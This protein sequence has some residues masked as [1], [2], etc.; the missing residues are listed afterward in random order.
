MS[1][2]VPTD[3]ITRGKRLAAARLH[4]KHDDHLLRSTDS[5]KVP[6]GISRP[7]AVIIRRERVVPLPPGPKTVVAGRGCAKVSSI[8]WH[9][10]SE[11]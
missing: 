9:P 7:V 5:R 11:I 2:L 1:H 6:A 8:A 3:P 10:G 4:I